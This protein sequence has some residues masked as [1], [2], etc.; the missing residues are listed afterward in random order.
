MSKR[1][2]LHKG[3]TALLEKGAMNY[4]QRAV[5]KQVKALA[6]DRL[7]VGI[8]NPAGRMLTRAYSRAA[9]LKSTGFLKYHNA[10]GCHIFVRPEGSQGVVLMD[11]LARGT[12]ASLEQANISPACVIET[13]PLNYQAWIRLAHAPIPEDLATATAQVLARRFG[14]DPN[15]ADWRHY[16][17]LAGFTN[18]KPAY[19]D[20]SGRY[21]FVLVYD[22]KGA[23]TPNAAQLLA[24]GRKWLNRKMARAFRPIV[25]SA[26][27]PD[28]DALSFFA[29]E[30]QG[31]AAR[32]GGALDHSRADWAICQKMAA[33]GYGRDAVALAL[34]QGS[35]DIENRK[36]GHVLDY[37]DRT[38]NKIFTS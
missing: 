12:L 13:S 11:D 3:A 29:D 14:T 25:A 15:S 36:A 38:L 22:A 1:C 28:T 2:A 31:F 7:E 23:I 4:T 19:V 30:F 37:I 16:G 6:V 5:N 34:A 24:A 10:A 8:L 26:D 9:L 18:R 20:E 35:P 32:Y 21:P 27:Q 17:R 33:K